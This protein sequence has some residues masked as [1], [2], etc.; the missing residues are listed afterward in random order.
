MAEKK[1]KA[2]TKDKISFE[3]ALESLESIVEAMEEGDIPLADLIE[4]YQEGSEYLKL[5]QDKLKDAELKI[6]RLKENNSG[7]V[8]EAL[9][10]E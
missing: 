10:S 1:A 9:E 8:I 3:K 2:K 7:A 6:E 5:C 4:K